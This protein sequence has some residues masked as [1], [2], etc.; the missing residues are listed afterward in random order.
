LGGA[1]VW[2]VL[3][4]VPNG[5]SAPGADTFWSEFKSFPS[6]TIMKV[7]NNFSE[8]REIN[9]HQIYTVLTS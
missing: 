7:L 8:K 5:A 6:K 2:G 1:W 9:R 4:T 3:P